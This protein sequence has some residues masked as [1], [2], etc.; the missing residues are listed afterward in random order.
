[1]TTRDDE[2]ST[3]P[4]AD[5]LVIPQYGLPKILLMY[6]W[7]VAWFAFLIYGIG[8]YFVRADG[9]Y[10]LWGYNL[11]GVLGN[12]AELIVALVIFRREG[13]R[14]TLKTLRERINLRLP[15]KL[16][17]WGACVGAFVVAVGLVL[18]TVPLEAKIATALPPPDSAPGRDGIPGP[19]AAALLPG[20][21]GSATA[22]LPGSFRPD[23]VSRQDPCQVPSPPA[24]RRPALPVQ[25]I[26]A[27]GWPGQ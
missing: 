2:R 10:P 27:P 5:E 8:P 25:A 22:Q 21:A 1:M 18:L 23:S 17:K 11:I 4:K 20:S 24:A 19:A 14:L 6:A 13:Y 12:G 9:T 3:N 15:D 16:W 26:P 7:P